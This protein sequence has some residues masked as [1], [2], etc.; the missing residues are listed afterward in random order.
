MV[1]AQ[2]SHP[3]LRRPIKMRRSKTRS[4]STIHE[5][6]LLTSNTMH[7]CPEHGL[8]NLMCY[9]LCID[10]WPHHAPRSTSAHAVYATS[11][12]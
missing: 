12:I 10:S 2:S 11:T 6:C 7:H 5:T 9:R 8:R 4:A 3:S 1:V